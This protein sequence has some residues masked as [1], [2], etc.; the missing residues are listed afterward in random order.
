MSHNQ[1]H[2]F[3]LFFM[4][5]EGNADENGRF[6]DNQIQPTKFLGIDCGGSCGGC[7]GSNRCTLK[8]LILRACGG[9]RRLNEATAASMN[10]RTRCSPRE[11]RDAAVRVRRLRRFRPKITAASG[12]WLEK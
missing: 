1:Q 3:V 9:L 2:R 5:Y 4:F 10:C 12:V 11:I 6:K 8:P 7:G